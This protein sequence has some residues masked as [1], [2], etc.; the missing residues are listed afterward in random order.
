[1]ISKSLVALLILCSVSAYAGEF[2]DISLAAPDGF[3]GPVTQDF[4]KQGSSLAYTKP[5][6]DGSNTL[7]QI[8]R[9]DL[10]FDFS[11]LSSDETK[12]ATGHYLLQF[13][14]GIEKQRTNFTRSE[15]QY[16]D[17]SGQPAA[18]VTWTGEI[19]GQAVH[20]IMYC[21]ILNSMIYSLHTQDWS[22]HKRQYTNLAVSS[23]ENLEVLD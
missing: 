23:I 17:I 9:L 5:H 19:A 3:N 7:L 15:V 4:G 11:D 18:K 6:G 16:L 14:S 20:G 1:M 2:G 22:S 10:Q 13:L 12:Q 21:M 8:S